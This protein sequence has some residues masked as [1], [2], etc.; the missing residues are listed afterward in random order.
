MDAP[1]LQAKAQRLRAL[2]VRMLAAQVPFAEI[3]G[4]FAE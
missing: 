4:F 2:H 3:Q 1:A